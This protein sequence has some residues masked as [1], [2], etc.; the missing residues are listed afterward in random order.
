MRPGAN[1]KLLW[2]KY[3]SYDPFWIVW[4]LVAMAISGYGLFL[5][6]HP[7][8]SPLMW[9]LR[10]IPA[11]FFLMGLVMFAR[12]LQ[13]RSKKTSSEDNRGL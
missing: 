4:G 11:I 13:L 7:A 9:L 8:R 12:Q 2:K 3:D 5:L 1:V 10:S 6:S